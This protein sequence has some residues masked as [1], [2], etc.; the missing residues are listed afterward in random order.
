MTDFSQFIE[1]IQNS[2]QSSGVGVLVLNNGNVLY[3]SDTEI[4][5]D[6]NIA[7]EEGDDEVTEYLTELLD[8]VDENDFSSTL[9]INEISDEG[10]VIHRAQIWLN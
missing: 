2:I 4:E 5:A 6:L 1:R 3:Y 10:S 9:L 7:T 8:T